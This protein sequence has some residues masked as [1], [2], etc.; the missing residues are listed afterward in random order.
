MDFSTIIQITD[1]CFCLIHIP[2]LP[3]IIRNKLAISLLWQTEKQNVKLY[4]WNKSKTPKSLKCFLLTF[5]LKHVC[6]LSQTKS[7]LICLT[8]FWNLIFSLTHQPS[9]SYVKTPWAQSRT[10]NSTGKVAFLTVKN[11]V[12]QSNLEDPA[13]LGDNAETP[14]WK[15]EIGDL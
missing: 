3:H 6:L 14:I 12:L 5:P 11:S 4:K 8:L 1:P 2:S 9:R 7:L 10:S 13:T 15:L